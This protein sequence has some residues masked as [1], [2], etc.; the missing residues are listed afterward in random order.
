M[1]I[2]DGVIRLIEGVVGKKE[3]LAFEYFENN[4]LDFPQYTRPV[5]YSG[6]KVPEVL[7]QGNHM[8]IEKWR[9]EQSFKITMK[10]R[11]DLLSQ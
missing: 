6:L 4:L 9:K 8:L 3:S 11:P 2:I 7:L 10:T 5:V 1:V